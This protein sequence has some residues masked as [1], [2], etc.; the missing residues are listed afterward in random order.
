M[1]QKFFDPE[2]DGKGGGTGGAG[3]AA[4]D[5]EGATL[6]AHK[7]GT[8]TAELKLAM[9]R[10]TEEAALQDGGEGFPLPPSPAELEERAA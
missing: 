3:L 4:I 2:D 8:L 1:N 9:E 5:A 7:Q 6:P 10:D